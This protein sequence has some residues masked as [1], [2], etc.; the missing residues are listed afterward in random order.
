MERIF[1]NGNN[2]LHDFRRGPNPDRVALEAL[3]GGNSEPVFSVRLWRICPDCFPHANAHPACASLVTSELL[4]SGDRLEIA[5]ARH[6]RNFEAI[7]FNTTERLPEWARMAFRLGVDEFN[8]LAKAGIFV[9]AREA[10]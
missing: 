9:E 10:A 2:Q 4:A 7:Q 5:L 8:G 3:G 1:R 6:G